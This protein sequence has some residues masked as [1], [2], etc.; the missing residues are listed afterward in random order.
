MRPLL[1]RWLCLQGA[2]RLQSCWHFCST[3][4]QTG[5]PPL[6]TGVLHPSCG[7]QGLLSGR[8][9]SWK[10]VTSARPFHR[11]KIL[12]LEPGPLKSGAKLSLGPFHAVSSTLHSECSLEMPDGLSTL[13]MRLSSDSL[14]KSFTHMVSC[15]L[16]CKTP[17]WLSTILSVKCKLLNGSAELP[18]MGP[19]QSTHSPL[20]PMTRIQP[21]TGP[22]SFF[23]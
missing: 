10:Q 12:S 16:R 19:G 20:A 13:G 3:V 1:L 14:Q 2:P 7:G 8:R 15:S 17:Q 22:S 11:Y 18:L 21:R 6:P 5:W 4:L 9:C 23:L